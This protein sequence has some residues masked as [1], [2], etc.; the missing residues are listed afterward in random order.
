MN[1]TDTQTT[2]HLRAKI[3][4]LSSRLEEAE[5]TLRAIRE[6]EVDAVIVS[7][8][9]GDRVFALSEAD[10]LHRLM[11]ETMNE[12]GLAATPDGLLVFCNDRAAALFGRAKE[13][14]LGHDLA[15]F[16]APAD[17]ERVRDLLR[18]ASIAPADARIEFR[19]SAG[20][21]VPMHVWASR[22][23]RL[24]STLVCLVATDLSR[25]EADRDLIAQLQRQREQ[26]R[27]SEER[28]QLATRAA[29][30]G[31]F[32]INLVTDTC[33]WC[34]QRMFDM[35]GRSRQDGPLNKSQM[36][37]QAMHP[38][39]V[40]SFEADA[41]AGDRSGQSFQ[42][43]FR[44]RRKSDGA[45]RW[46][47]SSLTVER[48]G[49]GQPIRLVGFAADI[50]ER[51]ESET[52]LRE[53][54]ERL[55]LLAENTGDMIAL[56]SQDG[57]VLYAS[58]S[59][60]RLVSGKDWLTHVH[61]DDLPRVEA[62]YQANLR[63]ENTTV[64]YRHRCTDGSWVWLESKCQIVFD[65]DGKPFQRVVASRDVTERKQAEEAL[66]RMSLLQA[67]GQ[68][69][70]HLGSFEYVADSQTTVW[71]EEEFRIY[72]L[73][74]A[75]QSPS[76]EDML[77]K[78]I[79]PDYAALLHE[80]FTAALRSGSVYELEH[81]IVR[82]DG[83]ARWV[84]DRAHP[85][86]D[87]DG[88]LVRYVGATLDITERKGAEQQ[89]RRY[90]RALQALAHSDRALL[91]L[92]EEPAYL[93][94]VCR[95]IVEDCGHAMVW[96]GFAEDDEGKT[97]RPVAS[98]GFEEGYLDSLHLTWAD[99]ERGRG[100]TG[101]AIRTGQFS[102]CQNMLADPQFAPWRAAALK[103]GYASSAVFPLLADG[104]A[105]GAL[106]IYSREA[107]AFTGDEVKLLS[108]LAGDF[109]FGI[110][111]LRLRVAHAAA[112]ESIRKL[113]AELEQRV[114]ARTAELS[115]TNRELEAFC[116]S[117]SHDLRA[118]LRSM[119]GFSQ[120]LLD[121]YSTRLDATG[122][123]FLRRVRSNTQR[124]GR[125]IDDLLNLSKIKQVH[126]RCTAVDL[127]ALAEAAVAELRKAEPSRTVDVRIAPGLTAKG[128]PVLLGTALTN[129]LENAWKFTGHSPDARV[130]VGSVSL[131]TGHSSLVKSEG[132]DSQAPMT[133]PVSPMT[134]DQVP[135]TSDEAQ[136]LLTNDQT[137]FF[138]RDNGVGFD[139]RYADKLFNPFQRLH[140]MEEFPGTG[141]GLATVKRVIDRHGG[142]VWFESAPGKGA[143]FYFIVGLPP[144]A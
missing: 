140:A 114:Q 136:P 46:I 62:A 61:P 86:F 132:T 8:S 133:V 139:M 60:A 124:M 7:G 47:E 107:E 56:H 81:R 5:E 84:Y 25:V 101:T 65:P 36:V 69:I 135:M 67:E 6:G 19:A 50:T 93:Q 142:R 118:P 27:E 121:D 111:T 39:D 54:E 83:S 82:P 37:E 134:N 117:V 45:L 143:T 16:A 15:E 23:E 96:V 77:A 32:E 138:V 31:V 11:V 12:A 137:V 71:S 94:E 125:L 41:E 87:G 59:M 95:I 120:A 26:L 131:V 112:E 9:K 14:L 34:N 48:D 58:P 75:R 104:Q 102:A 22:L 74:P 128:D 129:L 72:G 53:S 63:G 24:D 126:M 76:Y 33:V 2:M 88:K 92:I 73:D 97:V 85:V 68:K 109:A 122:R 80:T 55:R 18:T 13:Q 49:S 103:R 115:A 144:I 100:P 119:D 78:H 30:L 66:A 64:E 141:I 20:M 130:E 28:L 90:N 4:E 35:F 70:A 42:T 3:A 1:K 127:S 17:A 38:D 116:Y 99:T 123:D 108:E 110:T 10:N 29:A 113:N 40:A 106:T 43:A 105:F 89:L 52:L 21:P 98:A 51:I 57:Q 44:I 91:R 79:H